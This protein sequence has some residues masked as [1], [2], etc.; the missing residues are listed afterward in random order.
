MSVQVDTHDLNAL[1]ASREGLSH[2]MAW[3][4]AS[5][6]QVME[7]LMAGDATPLQKANALARLASLYL[8]AF[9]TT[10]LEK[11]NRALKAR[12]A[13]LDAQVAAAEKSLA[14]SQETVRE[15]I[16][17]WERHGGAS[18][19]LRE[20]AGLTP[21]EQALIEGGSPP[22]DDDPMAAR[23]QGLPALIVPIEGSDNDDTVDEGDEDEEEDW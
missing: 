6:R 7:E 16:E 15:W 22:S 20:R 13:E 9:G 4:L 3:L 14:R 5:L 8:K 2:P 18:D 23:F 17:W 21:T 19:E 1:L 10:E 11:E 12:A